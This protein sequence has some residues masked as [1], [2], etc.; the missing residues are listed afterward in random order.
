MAAKTKKKTGTSQKSPEKNTQTVKITHAAIDVNEDH[1]KLI[2]RG[3]IDPESLQHLCIDDYQRE[4]LPESTVG[5]IVDGLKKGSAIPDITLGM[6]GSDCVERK[7]DGVQVIYLQCPT[8]IIDG[9]Q[10]RTAAIKCF[11]DGITPRLGAVIYLDSDYRWEK[12]MFEA[13]N[14]RGIRLNGNVIIRNKADTHTSVA[15]LISMT[16]KDKSFALKDRVSWGQRKRNDEI[17]TASMLCVVSSILMTGKS[18]NGTRSISSLQ[19][20]FDHYGQN[21]FRA[22]VRTFFGLIDECWGIRSIVVSTSSP[23]IKLGFMKALAQV[24]YDHTN[25]WNGN[26][27]SITKDVR[28]KIASFPISD[29]GIIEL[30]SSAGPS[31]DIL[32]QLIMK[33]INRGKRSRRLEPRNPSS[34]DFEDDESSDLEDGEDDS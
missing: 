2:I 20:A 23:W 7:L 3:R 32:A 28:Q 5:G 17:I 14:V 30:A 8:Y 9:L 33:H 27:L 13:L 29:P 15:N 6:R 18:S 4:I 10:R 22:N 12:E 1:G 19:R 25:F 24:L 21:N 16:T 31:A 11:E 34:C 26:N